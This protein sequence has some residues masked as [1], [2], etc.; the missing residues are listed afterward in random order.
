MARTERSFWRPARKRFYNILGL[1][2][3]MRK[4]R[5]FGPGQK[6]DGSATCTFLEIEVAKP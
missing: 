4:S 3:A 6:H 2:N 5:P 1:S